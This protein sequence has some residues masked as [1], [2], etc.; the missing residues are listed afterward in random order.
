[1]QVDGSEE[2]EQVVLPD[3]REEKTFYTD[4]W[5]RKMY[6]KKKHFIQIFEAEKWNIIKMQR[7]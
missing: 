6:K 4:I 2:E 7:G 1:M 3:V 5:G